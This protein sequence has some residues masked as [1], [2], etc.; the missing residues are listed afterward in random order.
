MKYAF[1]NLEVWQKSRKL[2]KTVYKLTGNF[3]IEEKY[4]L[5]SQLR[6]ASVS[7]SSNIA[8]GSTRWSRKDQAR[9][10]EISFGSLIEVL[11]QAILANDLDF[12]KDDALIN[13]RVDIDAIGR[14]INSL[15]KYTKKSIN[16]STK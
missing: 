4:G 14:M 13:I 6:R 1:E 8:E 3:P 2:V 11:N 9:F 5:T 15:Y 12:L 10:Y 7:V 16:L